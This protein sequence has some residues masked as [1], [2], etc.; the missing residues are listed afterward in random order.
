MVGIK[1]EMDNQLNYNARI[2]RIPEHM[3]LLAGSLL[4][5]FTPHF[6][7]PLLTRFAVKSLAQTR[8]WDDTKLRQ[9]GFIPKYGLLA[10]V[11]DAILD[12]KNR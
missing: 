4:E 9:L 8:I 5:C 10:S 7:E 3:A 11:Q 1:N 2:L 12:L 6:K